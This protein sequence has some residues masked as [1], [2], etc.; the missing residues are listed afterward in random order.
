VIVAMQ[1]ERRREKIVFLMCGGDR[2][3]F[4]KT[5]EYGNVEV[6]LSSSPHIV[7]T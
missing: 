2:K 4:L 7:C 3:I 1:K 5:F 6:S